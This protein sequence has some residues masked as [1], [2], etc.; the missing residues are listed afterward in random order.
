MSPLVSV[1]GV[2]GA[3]GVRALRIGLCVVGVLHCAIMSCHYLRAPSAQVY[4]GGKW[5]HGL[6]R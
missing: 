3:R 1:E 2:G 4:V 6:W 5:V